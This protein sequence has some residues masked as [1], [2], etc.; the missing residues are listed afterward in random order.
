MSGE[1]PL[2]TIYQERILELYRRPHGKQRLANPD[3]TG[4]AHN[5]LCG[6][7]VTIMLR[8]SEPAGQ[9][10]ISEV[11]FLGDGCSVSQASA[12]M[13]TDA[14]RGRSRLDAITLAR[15][16]RRHFA[17]SP[18]VASGAELPGDLVTLTAIRRV[19]SRVPCAL[20]P[21]TALERA[22]AGTDP[23]ETGDSLL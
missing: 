11:S 21:W 17:P 19:P 14:V 22:L 3:A 9:G 5:P 8:H 20:L 12:S 16:L 6:E 1:L 23:V 4:T 15:T 13:L 7:D 2:E 18:E 10:I